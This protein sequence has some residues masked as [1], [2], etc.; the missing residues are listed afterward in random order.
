MSDLDWTDHG[1]RS[2]R[3]DDVYFSASDGLAE[4]RLV[5]LTGTGLPEAWRGR[6]RFTV[7]ELGFGTGL[8]IAALLHLWRTERPAGGR[9][10]IFSVEAYPI[11]RAAAARALAI[12]PELVDV[13][14]PLLD[15]WPDGRTGMHRIDLPGLDAT[16]DLF[17]GEAAEAL[18]AWDGAADAWFLDGFAPARNPQMW[19]DEVLAWVAARSRPGARAATFTVAGQVRQGLAAVGFQLARRPGFG[20]KRERLETTLPGATE[21]VNPPR[22]AVV[23]GA[24]IAGV[25]LARVLT[26]EGLAC[27]VVDVAG[28]GAGASGNPA[29]LVTPRLDAG[30]GPVARLYAQAFARAAALYRRSGAVIAEGVLQLESSARDR[31]RFARIAAWDGFAPGAAASLPRETVAEL[32]DE[33]GAGGGLLFGDGLAIDPRR[34]LEAWLAGVQFRQGRATQL[35]RGDGEW[36]VLD[37]AGASLATAEVVCIALGA[38]TAALLPHLGLQPVRGQLEHTEA[39]AFDGRAAAWG[40]YAIPTPGGGVLFG[41]SHGRGDPGADLRPDERARNLSALAIGRP[42]LAARMAVLPA[43]AIHSRASVRA[44]MPDHLPLTGAIAGMPGVFVLGGLGGRGFTLAP[45]LAEHLAAM[46]TGAPSPLPRDLVHL[47]A[48]ERYAAHQKGRRDRD[49][50]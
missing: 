15:A 28:P 44:A 7:A 19:R 36:R 34:V 49:A 10:S 3:F 48:P 2:R 8:N 20:R 22:S 21:P 39:V 18:T 1:P 12:W 6:P 17:I 14:A 16:L 43:E 38:G 45:L 5:F 29:A 41:A 32:L 13:T 50:P 23:L 25:A 33:P 26:A 47:V 40:G 35:A 24:G 30:L 31:D 42:A 27:T 9:L 46:I 11:P 37:A 4:S